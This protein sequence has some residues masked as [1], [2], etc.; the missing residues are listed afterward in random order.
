MTDLHNLPP[1]PSNVAEQKLNDPVHWG[2]FPNNQKVQIM[3]P[4][5][6]LLRQYF[7][8]RVEASDMA[9]VVVVGESQRRPQY[10]LVIEDNSDDEDELLPVDASISTASS[11]RETE[12][13]DEQLCEWYSNHGGDNADESHSTSS[14][15]CNSSHCSK[16]SHHSALDHDKQAEEKMASTLL[17]KLAET[18]K[19]ERKLHRQLTQHG[20]TAVTEDIPY[21]VCKQKIHE[22]AVEMNE[23]TDTSHPSYFKLEQQM[24]KYSASLVLTD[25]YQAEQEQL[26][27]EWEQANRVDNEEALKRVRRHMPVDV[28]KQTVDE[29]LHTHINGHD[30]LPVALVKRFKRTNVLTLIRM[31]PNS[32]ERMHP[33][34]LESMRVTGLTLTERRALYSHLHGIAKTWSRGNSD[35]L[36]ARKY[37]WFC[38]MKGNF[39]EALANYQ[40]HV[41]QFGNSF[42]HMCPMAGRSCPVKAD[43]VVDYTGD[44][45]YPEGAVYE[46]SNL[47]SRQTQAEYGDNEQSANDQDRLEELQLRTMALKEHYK[48][49]ILEMTQASA[50]CESMDELSTVIDDNLKKWEVQFADDIHASDMVHEFDAAL[51]LVKSAVQGIAQRAGLQVAG[52]RRLETTRDTRSWVETILA[53]T[54]HSKLCQYLNY[55]EATTRR[56][57]CTFDNRILTNVAL[58]YPLLNDICKRNIETIQEMPK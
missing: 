10:K 52:G 9:Y 13:L 1:A 19:R 11:T 25:E 55:M 33:S 28:R 53:E 3:T 57:G 36:T 56:S 15:S 24:E 41:K 18:E 45:G 2:T 30:P 22:L 29:L 31:D 49:R 17:S 46:E 51:K 44:Y 5:Q 4:P 16:S 40:N 6:D 26:E 37:K 50:S 20:M 34:T 48:G 54:L 14:S 42:L 35:A 27:T 12:D 8:S 43:G 7:T 58:L 32:I 23:I 38:M 21:D 47:L 39:K